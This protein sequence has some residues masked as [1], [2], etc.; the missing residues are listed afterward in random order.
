MAV[1]E[2]F[3]TFE[4]LVGPEGFVYHNRLTYTATTENGSTL[5]IT[6]SRRYEEIGETTVSRPLW[7]DE[8]LNRTNA[9][10]DD[11]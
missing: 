4:G 8:A 11:R 9:T 1:D 10:D 5:R 3:G 2:P 7:Y 6:E